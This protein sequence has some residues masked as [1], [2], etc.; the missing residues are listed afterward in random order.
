MCNLVTLYILPGLL[1]ATLQKV[2]SWTEP[3]QSGVYSVSGWV[4]LVLVSYDFVGL[5][6]LSEGE[7]SVN[8]KQPSLLNDF[9]I[10][11]IVAPFKSCILLVKHYEHTAAFFY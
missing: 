9:Q 6:L 8:V 5:Y 4:L 7:C 1:Q 10:K 11:S 2:P 3:L